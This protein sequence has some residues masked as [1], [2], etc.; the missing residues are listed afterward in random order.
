MKAP[1]YFFLKDKKYILNTDIPWTFWK[2][3]PFMKK[4]GEKN[5]WVV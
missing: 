1:E 2:Q 5:A 4:S 3:L